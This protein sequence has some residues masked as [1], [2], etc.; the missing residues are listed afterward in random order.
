MT[1]SLTDARFTSI[2]FTSPHL[3]SLFFDPDPETGWAVMPGYDEPLPIPPH[4]EPP[5]LDA[6]ETLPS[7]LHPSYPF[8]RP[9]S[10]SKPTRHGVGNLLDTVKEKGEKLGVSMVQTGLGREK[11]DELGLDEVVESQ[12]RKE[13]PP[14]MA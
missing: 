1:T 5:R 3:R 11:W 8:G 7:A 10:V 4:L 13:V 14:G 9:V 2:H 6:D 12:V